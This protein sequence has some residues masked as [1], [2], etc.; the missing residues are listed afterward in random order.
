VVVARQSRA[1]TLLRDPEQYVTA[2]EYDGMY[3][4]DTRLR[5]A[6]RGTDSARIWLPLVAKLIEAH[7]KRL[8]GP[9]ASA[10]VSP[11]M[12]EFVLR[13]VANTT[14]QRELGS[15]APRTQLVRYLA[16][17]KDPRALPELRRSL[18]SDEL[19]EL[20]SALRGL[21]LLRDKASRSRVEQL[22]KHETPAVAQAARE[23]LL[24]LD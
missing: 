16:R 8:V 9:L 14:S 10:S 6:L 3:D 12:T 17:S 21:A 11:E 24:Q 13:M 18:G 2:D 4:V 15:S 23:A 19:D 1:S 20:A 7:P 22:S 5:E